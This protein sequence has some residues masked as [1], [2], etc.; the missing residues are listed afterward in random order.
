MKYLPRLTDR[1]LD[2]L[3]PY[4]PAVSIHGAKGVGKTA[5]ADRRALSRLDLD[6]EA[7]RTRLG[8]DPGLLRSLPGPVLVDEWQRMPQAWDLVRRA[9]DDGAPAGRFLLTGSSPP[10]GAAV[11]SGAGRVVGLWMR[12]MSLYERGTSE[13]K[14]SLAAMLAG[15]ADI[16]GSTSVRL[17]DYVHEITRSG[18][19]GLRGDSPARVVRDSLD[20]YLDYVVRREFPDQG[21]QVRRPDSLR[22]WLTAYAAA[23]STT[24]KYSQ[25]LDAATPNMGDKPD[26]HTTLT[27]RAALSGL[28]LLDPTPA[29]LPHSSPL[30]R[31]AQSAKHQLADPALAARLLRMDADS[32]LTGREGA[33]E[34][35]TRREPLLGAL[36][37]S[38]V[39]L[40]VKVYADTAEADVYHLR[41]TNGTHEVDLV[42][43]GLGHRVVALEVKLAATPSDRD[44]RHLIWLKDKLGDRLVD[45]AV[46]C[47][48]QHAYRRAD[49]V[50][51][52][53]AAML[54][55]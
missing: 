26:R 25:I 29:W 18:L 20:A 35:D 17:A 5:T 10:R 36:F 19:P 12:P 38:L 16:A 51:V 40:D 31:L 28:W 27:Y 2:E 30:T 4:C 48:S 46:I 15:K 39:T 33:V 7:D 11:H 8:G 24:A 21:Y 1:R 43:E 14:V 37:E 13:G 52:V 53:P 41:D 42:V 32:L 54:G 45:M 47:T 49:G 50:A 3:L 9:V 55:P 34:V 44:V 6:A 23:S 22:A